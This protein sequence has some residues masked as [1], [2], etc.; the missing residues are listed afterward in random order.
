MT[1]SQIPRSGERSLSMLHFIP[2]L[3][4]IFQDG[5]SP[6]MI[7]RDMLDNID[8]FVGTGMAQDNRSVA[9]SQSGWQR[10]TYY[11]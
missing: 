11:P 3:R 7:S 9:I 4:I 5:D 8:S 2:E 6:R 10:C 1:G